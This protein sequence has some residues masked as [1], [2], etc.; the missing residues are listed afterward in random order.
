MS[1]NNPKMKS[2]R[3]R[4]SA[5]K[6]DTLEKKAVSLARKNL[7]S[8]KEMYESGAES[9]ADIKANVTEMAYEADNL[10]DWLYRLP[11]ADQKKAI[12]AIQKAWTK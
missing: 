9:K 1:Y 8:A 12:R 3:K 4:S 11:K 5:P 10:G 6:M 2:I 7:I